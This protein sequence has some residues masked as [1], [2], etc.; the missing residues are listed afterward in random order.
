MGVPAIIGFSLYYANG[1]KIKELS[2]GDVIDL[3]LL[4]NLGLTIV[5]EPINPGIG[6]I[7]FQVGKFS[8]VENAAP[9]ALN[10]D[11][12][13]GTFIAYPFAAGGFGLTCTLFTGQNGTG[14]ILG[15]TV[16][17][18]IFQN[19]VITPPSLPVSPTYTPVKSYYIA[20]N[21]LD[22][23]PGTQSS[24]FKTFDRAI[25]QVN[26]DRGKNTYMAGIYYK[27]GGSVYLQNNS[28]I[29]TGNLVIG[30]WGQTGVE[31]RPVIHS[32][33]GKKN[34][35]FFALH[36][37][38][39]HFQNLRILS[40]GPIPSDYGIYTNG[41]NN[42]TLDYCEV[43]GFGL[44]VCLNGGSGF[45]MYYSYVGRSW[46]PG[47]GRSQGL[48]TEG[49]EAPEVQCSVFYHNGWKPSDFNINNPT[50]VSL[51]QFNHGWYESFEL[52]STPGI[53]RFNIWLSN[54]CTGHQAR[55]GGDC[56]WSVI[57]GNGNATDVFTEGATATIENAVVFGP[58]Q[59]GPY[60]GG[61][62]T[63]FAVSQI[64]RNVMF[65]SNST[66]QMP[67][68]VTIDG[69]E[70][71]GV[72][73]PSAG[74]K[75]IVSNIEGVWPKAPI[76]YRKGRTGTESGVTVRKPIAGEKLPTLLDYFGV[77]T[78]DEM[79]ELLRTNLHNP[80]YYVPSIIAWARQNIPH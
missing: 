15:S 48:Y 30:A 62:V 34:S 20:T 68:A 61:G 19:F 10:G 54:A 78:D 43:E 14:T 26:A 28:G 21:G 5:A 79:A 38:G 24:P 47:V 53:D 51:L 3:T 73:Q 29:N 17:N 27:A 46:V 66:Q 7:L 23:N 64:I 16:L 67:A 65:C 37:N 80:K 63:G 2:Q 36:L 6:S 25:K 44:N 32:V 52:G 55:V 8:H 12:P 1:Q 69:P 70:I 18:L 49:A 22:T 72:V 59:A 71:C 40:D 41:C 35:C 56:E 9:Y 74:S 57:Q 76:E 45:R 50:H 33:G 60:W 31:D 13:D 42:F 11:N 77:K 58:T 4:S 39:L 75:A